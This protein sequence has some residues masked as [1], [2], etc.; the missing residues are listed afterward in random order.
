MAITIKN[1]YSA[2]RAPFWKRFGFGMSTAASE[3]VDS[4]FDNDYAVSWRNA[5]DT[6]GVDVLKLDGSNVTQLSNGANVPTGKTFTQTD[7]GAARL[8]RPRITTS[9]DDAN[10]NEVIKTPA[11]TN[12][13]NEITITNAITSGVPTI[14][15]TGDDAS[16]PIQLRGKGTG[17]VYL[18][19]STCQ[20]VA[21]NGDQPILD[22]SNNEFIKFTKVASAVNEVTVSNAATGNNPSI[23][24]TG[25]DT[26]IS[27]SLVGKGTGRVLVGASGTATATGGAATCSYQRGTV[28]SEGLTTAAGADYTL[29]LTNTKVAATSIVL[30]TADNGTNTTEGLAINR[31]TPGSG[32]VVILVRNT[33]ASSALN[34]TIKVN[35]VVL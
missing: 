1:I 30:A 31:V 19:Q 26:N 18:G 21:L 13:V 7:A 16:V 5:A 12:A 35:F 8:N 3:G 14:D 4:S 15:A 6:A 2:T 27:L 29:T 25:D 32:S 10:G 23:T 9:I 34:G 22:S 17:A 24:P 11:T 20:G 28:T 33:H